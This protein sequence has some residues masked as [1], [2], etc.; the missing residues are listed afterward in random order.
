MSARGWFGFEPARIAGAVV[1][2]ACSAVV[3][4]TGAAGMHGG[5]A[6]VVTDRAPV[7]SAS[8]SNG[9]DPCDDYVFS[10]DELRDAEQ[11]WPQQ[12]DDMTSR[13]AGWSANATFV[14]LTMSCDFFDNAGNAIAHH[15]DI[16]WNGVFYDPNG[17][18]ARYWHSATGESY[19]VYEE[20]TLDVDTISFKQLADWLDDAGVDGDARIAAVIVTNNP[21]SKLEP[22]GHFSYVVTSVANDGTISE[23]IVDG[24]DGAVTQKTI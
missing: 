17:A 21:G 15:D 20:T 14:Q 22:D 13:A 24:R 8:A 6:A 16:N 7:L 19:F 4:L 11:Q 23:T 1:A 2:L 18:E 9:D 12:R 10:L 5:S 3:A